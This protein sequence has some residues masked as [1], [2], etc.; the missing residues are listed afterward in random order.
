MTLSLITGIIL[1][2]GPTVLGAIQMCNANVSLPEGADNLNGED[3]QR[4]VVPVCRNRVRS[5][6]MGRK[7]HQS[8]VIC[9]GFQCH[10]LAKLGTDKTDVYSSCPHAA[11]CPLS[12]T[13]SPADPSKTQGNAIHMLKCFVGSG[14]KTIKTVPESQGL[15]CIPALLGPYPIPALKSMGVPLDPRDSGSHPVH[16]GLGQTISTVGQMHSNSLHVYDNELPPFYCAGMGEADLLLCL[17]KEK[18]ERLITANKTGIDSREITT[19]GLLLIMLIWTR[20]MLHYI[21]LHLTY[22][23]MKWVLM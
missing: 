8:N 22:L 21:P 16:S 23:D 11:S 14:P 4:K 13:A 10:A 18:V 19:C 15:T 9:S 12:L 7:K 1:N 20:Q 17:L 5:F 2:Q 3:R 6:W